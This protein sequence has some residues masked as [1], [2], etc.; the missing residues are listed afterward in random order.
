MWTVV[1][2]ATGRSAADRI[3]NLLKEE[4]ILAT[5]RQSSVGGQSGL[6]EIAVLECE[7]HE[8]QEII[9]AHQVCCPKSVRG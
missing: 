2:I 6:F 4:G 8:A 1:H 9:R 7:V 5:T 3:A